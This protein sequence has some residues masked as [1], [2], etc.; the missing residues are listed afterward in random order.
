[1]SSVHKKLMQARVALHAMAIKKSGRNEFAKYD[2]MELGDFIMPSQKLLN[3]L[4]LCGVVS[5]TETLATLT[6][7]DVDDNS[8]IIIT[9]P[10][11]SAAL[12]GCHEVQNIGAVET[13]QRR[14]LWVTALEIVE[15]DALDG[16]EPP[17]PKKSPTNQKQD[18]S[19]KARSDRIKIGLAAGD[20]VGCA[21]AMA[22]WDQSIVDAVWALMSDTEAKKLTAAWPKV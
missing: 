1:M 19:P 11:G 2:Y 5:Y 12:K 18:M 22:E 8:E 15:H 20:A 10:M 3:D 4:G 9:S 7:S 16:G 17:E 14:Y 13:Y 6:I 21:L